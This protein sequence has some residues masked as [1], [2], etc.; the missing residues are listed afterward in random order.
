MRP[1]PF[2]VRCEGVFGGGWEPPPKQTRENTT[3]GPTS[4]LCDE[5]FFD[6]EHQS[7]AFLQLPDGRSNR[8]YLFQ[9]APSAPSFRASDPVI[10]FNR[11]PS[12]LV[13]ESAQT[14]S[15]RPGGRLLF[16]FS[17][18]RGK[19]QETIQNFHGSE[20]P[21]RRYGSEG[22]SYVRERETGKEEGKSDTFFFLPNHRAICTRRP[23]G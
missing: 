19:S 17:G 20:H 23:A 6:Q 18:D 14:K 4:N 21:R 8:I 10:H 5:I 15:D 2:Q 13:S 9:P 7:A 3:V 22:I 1:Q 16:F 12:F 11:R